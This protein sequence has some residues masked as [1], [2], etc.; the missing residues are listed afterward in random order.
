MPDKQPDDSSLLS[1]Y[2][3]FIR[4]HGTFKTTLLLVS[5][6][7][8]TS[9]VLTVALVCTLE[10][11]VSIGNALIGFL[12]PAII[13]PVIVH[14]F[15][16]LVARLDQAES[17]MRLLATEDPLT[18]TYNRRHFSDLAE[19]AW[20]HAAR[21]AKPLSLLMLDADRFKAINDTYG[22]AAGDSVLV[23]LAEVCRENLRASDVVGRYGG[24]EF[25]ILLSET[26]LDEA[27]ETAERL[28]R[29]LELTQ[30]DIAQGTITFT[31]SIGV[32]TKT[33]ASLSVEQLL[34]QADEA[35]LR[36][37]REGRNRTRTAD[38]S[39]TLL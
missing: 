2:R 32:A 19:R 37:K 39:E 18:K 27:R 8:V 31:V 38:A 28:R 29:Q 20:A 30:V 36:A 7:V 35:L 14:S 33:R 25:V 5:F 10:G 26:D 21:H 1:Y 3:N 17:Q 34:E 12:I 22:H 24:E 11:T 9:V 15:T 16:R 4:V 13:T 23:K 6:S